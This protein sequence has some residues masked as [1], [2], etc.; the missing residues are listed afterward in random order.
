MIYS[1]FQCFGYLIGGLVAYSIVIWFQYHQQLKRF[2]GPI[3]FPIIGC[4][5]DKG[6]LTIYKH[7]LNLRGKYGNMYKVFSFHK[8]LLVI[9][10]PVVARRILSD[11][12]SFFKGEDYTKFFALA[13]GKG[14][15]TANGEDHRKGRAI[16]GKYFIRSSIAKYTGNFNETTNK[17]IN[18]FLLPKLD[19][20]GATS[21]EK[22][23]VFNIEEFFARLAFRNFMYF[24]CRTDSSQDTKFETEFCH[25][26]AK[27]SYAMARV[28][29]FKEPYLPSI[30]PYSGLIQ[31]FNDISA[32]Y[33]NRC[34]DE[35]KRRI[36]NGET[37]E[38]DALTSLMSDQTLTDADRADHF[39][40]LISAGHD[41]TAL[42]MSYM[43]YLL[44]R[45]PVIQ[46]KL[47]DYLDEKLEGGIQQ[48]NLSIT[49]DVF[50]ELKY[51]H[52]VMMETLR[53]YAIIPVVTRECGE[54]IHIKE[55]DIEVTIPKNI[56]ILIPM[57]VMNKDPELWDNPNEFNPS[58]FE[59]KQSA[60][61]TSA[62]D[63]FFPFAYGTRTCIGNTMAQI[64]SAIAFIHLLRQFII[65]E[66][67]GF[68]PNILAGISLTTSN[69]INICLRKRPIA[70][71]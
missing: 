22:G 59:N 14:L 35:R 58:R 15:V 40:T 34:I 45:N 41:T 11:P 48:P 38:E 62:K 57:I 2:P 47:Y 13:F 49:A 43:A 25:L 19:G 64:E 33:L 66:D 23:V 1:L 54:D 9:C 42:F 21:A 70:S 51:L 55:A 7:L 12:K 6:F 32:R 39:K 8:P 60:D 5:Y 44:A 68:R 29:L 16:L 28:L 50:A 10:H 31:K 27:G 20:N 65:E 37:F 30:L 26:V 53:L 36:A 61:F 56:T 18:E 67:K 71:H 63:G 17:M 46:Q 24:C 4:C 69:G 52:F 3:S